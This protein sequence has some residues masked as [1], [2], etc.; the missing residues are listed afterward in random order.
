L[1]PFEVRAPRAARVRERATELRRQT[2]LLACCVLS[3]L[4]WSVG[5]T[6]LAPGSDTLLAAPA[7]LG[8][9]GT[10]AEPPVDPRWGCLGKPAAPRAVALRPT[11][12][13]SLGL[14][15]PVRQGTPP[16]ASMRACNRFDID[17]TAPVQGPATP[18]ADGLMHLELPQGFAGFLEITSPAI[19]PALYFFSQPLQTDRQEEFIVVSFDTAVALAA[20][21]AVAIDPELGLIAVRTMDC[22]GVLGGGVEFSNQTGGVPFAFID[23]LPAIGYTVSNREGLGGFVNVPPGL[24]ILEGQ[25]VS[26]GQVTGTVSVVVRKGWFSYGDLNPAPQ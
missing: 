7:P 20:S 23:G 9:A 4:A 16:D 8:A 10:D 2:L 3:G 19:I 22:Q 1:G 5:C 24:V 25:E 18:A 12:G 21:G 6:E 26:S 15:D 11:V 14:N 17:C 13:F